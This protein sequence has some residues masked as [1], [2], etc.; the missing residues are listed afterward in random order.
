[1]PIL[2]VAI[3]G[4]LIGWCF[5]ST[6]HGKICAYAYYL[7]MPAAY[8]LPKVNLVSFLAAFLLSTFQYFLVGLL[9]EKFVAG[10]HR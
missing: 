1:M 6:G 10:V 2:Y 3:E 7:L 9:M 8:F 4:L 5:L